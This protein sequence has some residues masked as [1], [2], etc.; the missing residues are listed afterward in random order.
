MRSIRWAS[1]TTLAIALA[2]F[3]CGGGSTKP[4]DAGV[5]PVDGPAAAGS[6]S[7]DSAGV[8]NDTA[9]AD[10]GASSPDSAVADLAVVESGVRDSAGDRLIPTEVGLAPDLASPDLQVATPDSPSDISAPGLDAPAGQDL[11]VAT[12]D[13]LSDT[14]AEDAL[15]GPDL[16]VAT[17]D[18][19]SGASTGAQDSGADAS[20]SLD[21]ASTG[22]AAGY[23]DGGNGTCVP[24][25]V[26]VTGYHNNGIGTCVQAGCATGYHN[27]G[28][29]TC[30]AA[31][32]CVTG[33]HNEGDGVC[34]LDMPAGTG[35]GTG[36]SI[37]VD[38]AAVDAA[39]DSAAP[40]LPATPDS[41]LCVVPTNYGSCV[42]THAGSLPGLHTVL[43]SADTFI[44][45]NEGSG[46]ISQLVNAGFGFYNLYEALVFLQQNTDP[47]VFNVM[48]ADFLNALDSCP[49]ASEIFT[50]LLNSVN[51][52]GTAVAIA[53]DCTVQTVSVFGSTYYGQA[54]TANMV[55]SITDVGNA[56]FTHSCSSPLTSW[57]SHTIV[58]TT[59]NV[60]AI[61][62][63]EDC[64][65]HPS[66]DGG[67]GAARS[68]TSIAAG[69]SY[70]CAVVNGGAQCWGDNQYG[71]LG[72]NS[73]TD[74]HVP[75]QVLG[76][77]SEITAV[78]A[79]WV[80]TCAVV[81]GGVQCWGDNLSGQLG[82]N[83]TTDSH[84]P[85]QVLGLTSG[86]TTIA[87]E[88]NHT[89][90]LVNG[91]VQCWGLNGYGQL[92]DNSTTDS[93]VPVQVLGL[94]SGVT[95]I[96]A[97]G[98]HTC[99][100]VNGGVQCWGFNLW[101]ELGNNS[102]TESHVPVQVRGLTSNVTA[103]AIGYN[104]TCALLVDGEMRCW[105]DNYYGE[106]G[107]NSTTS[108]SVPVLVQFP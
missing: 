91:G 9:P 78:A 72:D 5:A 67:T 74:S 57:A 27:G 41:A 98:L 6:L 73:T 82:D 1:S 15:A 81:N 3:G 94:T 61:G 103:V 40:D 88:A 84:V 4:T 53:T 25:G 14:S 85:V 21:L 36:I 62:W 52:P 99:A 49:G 28:D 68:I 89:C 75:V 71:R 79:G 32:T 30:V 100:L 70:T 31:G 77:T 80:H 47:P 11:A 48:T 16:A 58:S 20:N 29:G 60:F 90:A 66:T 63:A 65:P 64:N 92:G 34:V 46:L 54:G 44:L 104:H 45:S 76:L 33:Y 87:A 83:S 7:M 105:G 108:S 50:T 18:S 55:A 38:A 26:C 10:S 59:Y 102:T 51:T 96:A 12:P 43:T 8:V 69:S 22:C 24:T 37:S 2:S 13:S 101:G 17:P 97:G 95:A 107:N 39:A 35:T 86:V 23:H 56:S 19:P 106:L 42:P 93:H